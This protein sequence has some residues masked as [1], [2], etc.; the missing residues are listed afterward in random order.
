MCEIWCR[1]KYESGSSE[2]QCGFISGLLGLGGGSGYCRISS[3]PLVVDSNK[4]IKYLNILFHQFAQNHWLFHWSEPTIL[5]VGTY[6]F[7]QISIFLL[8]YHQGMILQ[9]VILDIVYVSAISFLMLLHKHLQVCSYFTFPVLCACL[10]TEG[11][12]ET[13]Q[14]LW[15]S[16]SSPSQREPDSFT[17]ICSLMHYSS[18]QHSLFKSLNIHLHCWKGQIFPKTHA[19]NVVWYCPLFFLSAL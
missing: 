11:K 6:Q 5:L 3:L 15:L 19:S 18:V 13:I 14:A 16:S 10:E 12:K 2:F 17:N 4:S 9:K 8:W 1:S 7:F